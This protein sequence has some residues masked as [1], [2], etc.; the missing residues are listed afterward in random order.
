ME[1]HASCIKDNGP[2]SFKIVS[3]NWLLSTKQTSSISEA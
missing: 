2:L 1:S 3:V